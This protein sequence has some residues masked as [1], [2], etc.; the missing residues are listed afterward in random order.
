MKNSGSGTWGPGPNFWSDSTDNVT[1]TADGSLRLAVTNVGTDTNP[2]WVCA[3]VANTRSLGYGTYTWSIKGDVTQFAPE[4]VLG[5]F[6]WSASNDPAYAY[7][8]ID[9]EYSKWA[10]P[11]ATKTGLFTVQTDPKNN[12]NYQLTPAPTSTAQFTWTK[13]SVAFK[14]TSGAQTITWTWKPSKKHKMPVP[15]DEQA[16]MN[17]WLSQQKAP[18]AGMRAIEFTSFTFTPA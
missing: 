12:L 1:V 10:Y 18:T 4:I 5:M 15:G 16:R 9:V 11:P 14:V 13:T 2:K 8:E 17:L 6:T 7:R 3:E